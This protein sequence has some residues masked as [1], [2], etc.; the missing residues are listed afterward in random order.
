MVEEDMT[1][2]TH[3]WSFLCCR[4]RNSSRRTST[5]DHSLHKPLV[6]NNGVSRKPRWKAVTFILGNEATES[7]AT[8][9]MTANL[10]V[11]L[12]TEYE[13]EQV[14]AANVINV[15][16]GATNVFPWIGAFIADAYLGK[17]LTVVLAS[18]ATLL[19][20]NGCQ[21][22]LVESDPAP[23]LLQLI[24]STQPLL[25]EGKRQPAFTIGSTLFSQSLLI[26]QTVAVYIQDSV[27]WALGFGFPTVLMFVSIL[28]FVAG[29]K[30]YVYEKP[31]GSILSGILRLFV[32]PFKNRHRKA[33]STGAQLY[34]PPLKKDEV[35]K[36]PLSTQLRFFNKAA[37]IVDNDQKP[38]GPNPNPWRLC[39]SQHVEEVKCM[40]KIIPIWASG[41]IRYVAVTQEVTFAVSQALK[42]DRRVGHTN[43]Q[44][45]AGSIRVISNR[46]MHGRGWSG[47]AGRPDVVTPMS[48]LWLGP[49]LIFLGFCE[50]FTIVGLS[51]FYNKE[52]P[53]NIRSIGYSLLYLSIAGASYL[54]SLLVD[55]V[56][57]TTGK[58]GRP[59]WLNDDINAGRLECF[60]FLLA[61]LGALNIV[62]FLFCARGYKYKAPSFHYSFHLCRLARLRR[63]R[64][65]SLSI[66]KPGSF[67]V[68]FDI[69]DK[70][71]HGDV[72][73]MFLWNLEQGSWMGV[74]PPVIIINKDGDH[75]K[76]KSNLSA[77]ITSINTS[78]EDF[79]TTSGHSR[80]AAPSSPLYLASTATFV[81]TFISSMP[82]FLCNFRL[83]HSSVGSVDFFVIAYGL[84]AKLKCFIVLDSGDGVS[85]TVPIHEAYALPHAIL[86]LDLAGRNLTDALMKILTERGHSFTTT[87]E[88]EIDSDMKEKLAYVALDYDIKYLAMD[89][90]W[91][92]PKET[93]L[94]LRGREPSV[95]SKTVTDKFIGGR[96]LSDSLSG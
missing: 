36:L 57:N 14:T 85:H 87:A 81:Y 60:Y 93:S 56:H 24:N 86:R 78:R 46:S 42:M 25:K 66:Y 12:M 73:E 32:V 30:Y 43:F 76:L 47:G 26:D 59:D 2:R 27:I 95:S 91:E 6:E 10:M 13:M 19:D 75:G 40:V 94:A 72:P 49:Q 20:Y 22:A 8:L 80:Q 16:Y 82:C 21:W 39:C 23:F 69:P 34:D 4:K 89:S 5:T 65:P 17:Y 54:S 53:H 52:F 62:Y 41:I 70:I 1:S 33:P 71:L 3:L 79:I 15:W 7:V 84:E 37:L 67:I 77:S 11:Y 55:I 50:V 63:P 90:S 28:L 88:R 44:I 83:L 48:V 51:E 64:S 29:A 61:G 35:E 18:F 74:V 9:G 45:L 58:N 96:E 38:D 31:Q 68:D 92:D